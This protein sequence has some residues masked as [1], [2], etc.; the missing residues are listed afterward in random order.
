ML[1]SHHRWIRAAVHSALL[2]VAAAATSSGA[3]A[4]EVRFTGEGHAQHP[5]W[6][7]DGKYVAFEVNRFA[8]DIKLMVSDVKPGAVAANATEVKL[9][10]GASAFGGG[11][12]VV[13]NP[14]WHPQGI[15]VF[16]GSNQSGAFRL[17]Y[18]SPGGAA[19]AEMLPATKAA[20][21]LT[22]PSISKD[23]NLM[24]YVSDRTGAGDVMSWNRNTDRIQQVTNSPGSE[25]FPQYTADGQSMVFTRK[26]NDTEAIFMVNLAAGVETQVVS[27]AGDQTRPV[28]APGNQVLYFTNER[29]QGN[30]DLAVIGADGQGKR[31]LAKG[32]RLPHRARPALSPDG[33]YV[34]F[35]YDDPTKADSVWIS[36]LDGVT[37]IE[38]PSG[39]K[40]CGE[41][42]L[43]R[44]AAGQTLL[45][46]TALPAAASDWRALHV[47]D[48]SS[49]L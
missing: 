24:A 19:A 9:P 39:F 33:K 34:A 47:I 15:M 22:F 45:A 28:L 27:G 18:A 1:K 31:V 49:R 30:W 41:P 4:G 11:G 10:G 21:D 38:V 43:T 8:G 20:G 35:T 29:G 6:S 40:A 3:F 2:L 7:L 17:Y 32:I 16:E 14:V 23:G 26:R 44:N 12:Q 48:V 37:T 46:F 5:V 13:V 25:M 36:S 42:A